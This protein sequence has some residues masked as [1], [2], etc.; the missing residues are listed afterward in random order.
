MKIILIKKFQ[1][2]DQLDFAKFSGDYNPMHVDEITSRRFLYGKPVVHGVNLVL[3]I[4]DSWASINKEKF[5]FSEINAIFSSPVFLNNDIIVKY[6]TDSDLIYFELISNDNLCVKLF[7]K[8]NLGLNNKENYNKIINDFPKKDTARQND[9]SSIS[10]MEGKLNFHLHHNCFDKMFPNLKKY[11]NWFQIS[12]LLTSTKLVGMECPGLNSIFS[13][14]NYNFDLKNIDTYY[15]VKKVNRFGLINIEINGAIN[16]L[17]K[18]FIRPNQ[19]NQ[20]KFSEIK[21]FVNKNEFKDQSPLIIGGSR[22]IGE[23]TAKILAAG[24]ANVLITY[25]KGENDAKNIIDDINLNGGIAKMIQYD[26][27]KDIDNQFKSIDYKPSDLYYFATPS[28]VSGKRGVFSIKLYN[29]YSLFYI[30]TFHQIVNFWKDKKVIN[31]FYPSTVYVDQ[32]PEN[33]LEY[34]LSKLSRIGTT[35]HW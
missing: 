5:N 34:S 19:V 7:F 24:G 33:M 14:F 8:L 29:L 12:A 10:L 31:Y 4:L 28:I 13:A 16:G 15:N 32:M 35:I 1:I 6:K 11:S 17:I 20:L 3:S 27:N 18:A 30:S 21:K 23:V 2:S 26:I 9:F 25:N 22:G